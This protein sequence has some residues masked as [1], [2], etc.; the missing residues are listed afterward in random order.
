VSEGIVSSLTSRLLSERVRANPTNEGSLIVGEY[1]GQAYVGPRL[2]L[3]ESDG[4]GNRPAERKRGFAVSLDLSDE[5]DLQLYDELT[6]LAVE[7]IIVFMNQ[8]IN[9]CEQTGNYKVLLQAYMP[10]QAGPGETAL[11]D[12]M[13]SFNQAKQK[14]QSNAETG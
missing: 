2:N 14:R 3:K 10:Y 13:T 9:F 1:G 11:N 12:V 5:A 7:G 8:R 6:N 4:P